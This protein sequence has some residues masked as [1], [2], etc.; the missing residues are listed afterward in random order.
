MTHA[1]AAEAQYRLG[2]H[3]TDIV[4]QALAQAIAPVGVTISVAGQRANPYRPVVAKLDR[5]R[6]DIVSPEIEG[7]A[8]NEIKTR[9]VPV[10]GQYSIFD[11]A[12]VQRE[13]E[14]RAPVV[15]CEEPASIITTSNGRLPPRT[16]AIPRALSSS[17][18]PAH[19]QSTAGAS[20]PRFSRGSVIVARHGGWPVH[21]PVLSVK[22]SSP[23][24]AA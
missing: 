1:T 18:V 22:R 21:I 13:T 16:T 7:P 19:T 4:L 23:I 14:M 17:T 20:G 9:V 12:T 3:E 15:E 5:S 8:A 2:E 10:A 24:G 6:R 11:R